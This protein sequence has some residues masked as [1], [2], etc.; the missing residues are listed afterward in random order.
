MKSATYLLD[1]SLEKQQEKQEMTMEKARLALITSEI[2]AQLDNIDML[3]EAQKLKA[4]Y[5]IQVEQFLNQ[6][7]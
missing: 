5:K 4:L 2:R 3:E 7:K 6:I 1:E